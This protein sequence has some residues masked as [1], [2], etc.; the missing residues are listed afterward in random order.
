M[1]E[2]KQETGTIAQSIDIGASRERV[3]ELMT[4]PEHLV[5][6]FPDAAVLE[7]RVGG[8]LQFTFGNDRRVSGEVTRYEPPAALAF[9]WVREGDE[10]RPTN[11]EFTLEEL[12]EGRCRVTLE[13][14][15]FEAGSELEQM[16]TQGWQAFLGCLVDLA[17]GRPVRKPFG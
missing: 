5:K 10:G 4:E 6:W 3:F 1:S 17:E 7:S 2:V 9:T 14:R 16:H 12:G 15:G 8:A 13:H 11:V